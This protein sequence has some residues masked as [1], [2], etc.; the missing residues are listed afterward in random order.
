MIDLGKYGYYGDD[1]KPVFNTSFYRGEDLYSDGD[2]E[3]EV[4]KIIA[5]N[6][7]T[8]YEEAISRNYSWPV[9]YHLTRI[10]QNLLNWY[11]FKE[12]SD[13][14]EIGCGMG[15]ITELLC[16]KCNSV[17]AVELSKR[18]ATATYLRCREYDNLEIIV[19]NLN[20]IQFNKKYDYI[21][22][23]GVLEYQNNFTSSSNPFKD[24]LAKI[25][26]LLKP[27][28]KLIIAIENKYGLKYWC[29]APEDH[30]G[31]PY[32]GIN[33]Y[34]Y[35]DVA[36]T[37]SKKQ[38]ERLIKSV[39]F[40]N[41]YFYYPLPDYKMP[42]VVYSEEYLPKNGS[43]DNWIPYYEPNGNSMVSDEEHIYGDLIDNDVFE[44][45]ANSF[46][47]E[48]C[49]GN[50]DIGEIQYAV[51]SPFRNKEYNMIT[52]Y[53]KNDGFYKIADSDSVNALKSTDNNHKMLDKRGLLVSETNIKG[54]V[55]YTKEISGTPLTEI[56]LREYADKNENEVYK[57]FDKIYEEIIRSSEESDKLNPIFNSS[58]EMHLSV[59]ESN[60][61]ILKKIYIDM[62]HKNCFVQENGDYVWIDQ[63]WCLDDIPAS[64]G[65][66]YNIIELYAS[67][68][69]IDTCIPMKQVLEHYALTDKSDCYYNL[70]QA[71]LNTVQNRYSTFNYWQLS[72]LNKDNITTNIKLLYNNMNNCPKQ[73]LSETEARINEILKNGTIMDVIEYVGTLTDEIILKDI[74]QMPQF[75]VR[76]LKASDNEK[77]VMQQS[78]KRYDDIKNM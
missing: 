5:A 69:W 19:G 64:F 71:F 60:D 23:I 42:Q 61:K 35:S 78:I 41:A 72:Q 75:I 4:I 67:N 14:L 18:R 24:F 76:Y 1:P 44:F 37:F 33:N 73:H 38:L 51:S 57:I 12:Q 70:K 59:L 28:G 27:E 58:D 39:G 62:I 74:P 43:M 32:D 40:N 10:R 56:L 16:K 34:A 49:A 3:N 47:V 65:L 53:S 46:M 29:G 26:Q 77:A 45:F 7:T 63:E 31:I 52:V 11:P 48:C 15:A 8:D 66:Y 50:E 21:T 17:T 68:M 2:I 30:S 55:M 9:F 54:N 36:R 20:D 6:P 25:K 13:I 22:L